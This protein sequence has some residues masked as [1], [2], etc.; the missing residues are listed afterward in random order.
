MNIFFLHPNPRK[1]AKWHCDKHVVKMIL[2]SCQLLYTA[3]WVFAAM[4]GQ[5]APDLTDAPLTVTTKQAGYKPTH[6]NH[7]CGKW[8]RSS[9]QHYLW[10][11]LL[12]AELAREYK[13]RYGATKI[14][15]C[16][17]HVAWLFSHTPAGLLDHGFS[18][19]PSAMPQEYR[20]SRDTVRNY[21]HFYGV[22]KE[23]RGFLKYTG[24]HRP[25]WLPSSG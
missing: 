9:L 19:P 24:R 8:V 17:A 22:A 3:H 4:V 21:R 15:A 14:H 11:C 10:L 1:C 12:A 13:H 5:E 2:E 6:R 7:P 18:A 25:H 20:I 23:Q 16:E